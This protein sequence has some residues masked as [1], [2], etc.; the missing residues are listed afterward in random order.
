MGRSSGMPAPSSTVRSAKSIA[1]G[2]CATISTNRP[3]LSWR[4]A[5]SACSVGAS[6][7][8][9]G[10]SSR[11]RSAPRSGA[12]SNARAR[13]V[14]ALQRRGRHRSARCAGEGPG[15][16][17]QPS[18]KLLQL[19]CPGIGCPESNVSCDCA[20]HQRGPLRHPGNV[21]EPALAVG[22]G[23]RH[24]VHPYCACERLEEAE[25]HAQ[26]VDFPQPLGAHQCYDLAPAQPERG[27]RK[28]G[29]RSVGPVDGDILH[30]DELHGAG[31]DAGAQRRGRLIENVQDLFRR[32]PALGGGVIAGA[33]GAQ[34]L[35]GS[36]ASSRTMSAASN[37]MLPPMRRSP[38]WTAT[39][40][41]DRLAKSSSTN[42]ERN[43]TRSTVMVVRRY[44]WSPSALPGAARA[45]DRIPEESSAL[46]RHRG[47]DWTC[48]RG[49][50]SI[51]GAALGG[52]S[53]EHHEEQD[54]GKGQQQHDP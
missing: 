1:A 16:R 25:H 37:S 17:T 35:E 2:R 29:D 40:A 47:N 31:R 38:T 46:R 51:V 49:P 21:A 33:K 15:R 43:D 18:P 5:A 32:R 28:G 26:H 23:H 10:S 14:D 24:A 8:A 12:G 54:N 30:G 50:P 41:T 9:V 20:G 52:Q 11:R 13:C 48:A 42:D 27:W 39:M 36:G 22:F 45:P 44:S 7:C 4:I 6:R 53:R 34:W 19:R 3:T